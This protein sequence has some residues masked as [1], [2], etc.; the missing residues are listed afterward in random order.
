MVKDSTIT[1]GMAKSGFLR[2]YRT[3][4]LISLKKVLF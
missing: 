2:I 1:A 4:Y 3:P